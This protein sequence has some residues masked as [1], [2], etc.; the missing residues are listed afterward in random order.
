[1][2]HL[3]ETNFKIRQALI[4]CLAAAFFLCFL[5]NAAAK[6]I[7]VGKINTAKLNVRSSPDRSSHVVVV[8]NKAELVNVLEILNGEGGWLKVEYQGL[9]GYIRNRPRYILLKPVSSPRTGEK[10]ADPGKDKA[11]D[12]GDET[13]TDTPVQ[14]GAGQ[15]TSLKTDRARQKALEK[16]IQ[17]ETERV[18]QFSQQEMQIL[19]GL[20]EIDMALN[21]A[22]LMVQSLRR[23]A[24]TIAGEIEQTQARMADLQ[25]EMKETR[26]YAHSRLNALFRMHR[27]GS[28]EMAGPPSSLFDFVITQKAL[29]KVV[30]ND[31]SLLET[32]ARDMAE[33]ARLEK[34][35]TRQRRLKTDLQDEMAAQVRIRK[36]EAAKKERIL[37]DIRHRKKLALAAVDS[38][39]ASA[40]ALDQTIA[41]IVP[42]KAPP[43]GSIP[44]NRQKGRLD[45]PVQGKITSRYGTTRKGEYNAFT[46]QSG[47]DIKAER[48]TPVKSVFNGVVMFAQ[49]MKGYGNL[50]IIDHGDSYHTVYAHVEEL[51]KKKGDQVETGEVI[52]TAGDTG[53]IKGPCLHFE[54]RHHGKPLNPLK[55][56]K[57]GA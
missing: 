40:R 27:M 52:G 31:Y 24:V 21:Q 8:L 50:L 44:F 15:K 16:Q 14:G 47:I 11:P 51:F 32:Q 13:R 41:A 33:L 29:K 36:K 25:K 20:N 35:L 3:P 39:E 56:L 4:A 30:E 53:S 22:R 26:S 55:W 10:D 49:W 7:Y 23:D 34:D 38:L 43:S 46:F 42:P 12:S 1:M 6:V 57:K 28:L 2:F 45:V 19:D 54:I 18:K 48:G 17:Q 9:T 5:D 37:K